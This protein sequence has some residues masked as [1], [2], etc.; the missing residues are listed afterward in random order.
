MPGSKN[1][2]IHWCVKKLPYLHS[3]SAYIIPPWVTAILSIPRMIT[4]ES[5]ALQ[6]NK[7]CFSNTNEKAQIHHVQDASH[8]ADS[9]A[10]VQ[11]WTSWSNLSIKEW[12]PILSCGKSQRA[13]TVAAIGPLK[14][15]EQH[16]LSP[17]AALGQ[18]VSFPDRCQWNL[19]TKSIGL[20]ICYSWGHTFL[21]AC[22]CN[23]HMK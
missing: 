14:I 1:K 15:A 2:T 11:L 19:V 18:F 13:M 10:E 4:L 21:L 23:S 12:A 3:I 8:C 17:A 16:W 9:L 5:Q 20:N 22:A 6:R 7:R